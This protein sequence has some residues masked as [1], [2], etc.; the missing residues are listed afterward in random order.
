MSKT[1]PTTRMNTDLTVPSVKRLRKLSVK[2]AEAATAPEP[3]PPVPAPPLREKVIDNRKEIQKTVANTV[4]QSEQQ[5]AA[6]AEEASPAS[7]PAPERLAADSFDPCLAGALDREGEVMYTSMT[8]GRRGENV[9]EPWLGRVFQLLCLIAFKC[10]IGLEVGPKGGHAHLQ[11]T[12]AFCVGIPFLEACKA[13]VKALRAWIPMRTGEKGYVQCKP[14]VGVQTFVG[15]LGYISKLPLAVKLW[16][17]TPGELKEGQRQYALVKTDP[18]SGKR[19]MNKSNFLKEVF[20]F[21]H[22]H[23]R[24]VFYEMETIVLYMLWSGEYMPTSVWIV[25]GSG[26][27]LD[28]TRAG[29]FWSLLHAPHSATLDDVMAIFFAKNQRAGR[30]FASALNERDVPTMPEVTLEV[31]KQRAM[32]ARTDEF[33]FDYA[34]P[35]TGPAH[36]DDDDAAHLTGDRF[37]QFDNR[38]APAEMTDDELE[39]NTRKRAGRWADDNDDDD[40]V[41]AMD[42]DVSEY[43]EH[44]NGFAEPASSMIDDEAEE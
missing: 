32:Q 11:I 1:M 30:Y 31:A 35:A 43:Q 16:N 15:M 38:G 3:A 13:I 10:A 41:G 5:A 40:V 20:S 24:P 44:D 8:V 36:D 42:I 39:E 7:A 4:I 6:P 26:E 33:T 12:A 2:A 18:L 29:R 21:W 19:P 22:R 23:L 37:M 17:V 27:G 34:E 25:G 14:L 9:F 28:F